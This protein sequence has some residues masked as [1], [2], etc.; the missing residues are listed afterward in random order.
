[1]YEILDL[2]FLDKEL[3][4]PYLIFKS[5]LKLSPSTRKIYEINYAG[6]ARTK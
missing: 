5:N 2:W 3:T 1:M 6:Q 4:S